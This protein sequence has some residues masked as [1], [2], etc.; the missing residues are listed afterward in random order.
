MEGQEYTIR[1]FQLNEI[2]I[3]DKSSD[4]YGIAIAKDIA[5]T[6]YGGLGGYYFDRNARFAKNENYA[7]GRLDV[8]AMFSDRFE[9]NGKQNYMNIGWQAV[10]IV[11]RIISGLVGRWMGRSEKAVVTAKDSLSIKEKNEEYALLEM[12]VKQ[13]D[14]IEQLQQ[15]SG[16]KLMPDNVPDDSDELLLWQAEFQRLPEEILFEIGIND[17]FDANGLNQA[18]KDKFL[19][20]GATD[21]IYGGEVE[22]GKDGVIRIIRHNPRNLIYSYS[23]FQDFRD[24]TWRGVATTIKIS[25]IRKKYGVEFGGKL[26]E[27][28]LWEIAQLSKNYQRNDNITWLDTWVN[29]YMR[30]Y[31]EWNLDSIKFEIKTVDNEKYTA[32]ETV[33]T[34]STIL[35]KGL[36]KTKSGNTRQK[37]LDNQEVLDDS[38]INI[39]R[40]VYLPQPKKLLEWGIKKNMIRPQDPKEIGNAEFSFSLYMYQNYKMRNIAIPE[41]I[42][43]PVNGMIFALLKIEQTVSVSKPPGSTI[44]WM[45][46]QN[47]SFGLGDKKDKEVDV[48]KL[49]NQTGDLYFNGW[50]AEG[51]PIPVPIQEIPNTG[52]L[53]QMQAWFS[54]YQFHYQTLKDQLGEDP[55]FITQAL[56]PRVT[57]GNVDTSQRAAEN[58]TDY[59]YDGFINFREDIGTKISCLLSDSVNFGAQAYRHLLSEKDIKG[60]EFSV[61]TKMLPTDAEIGLLDQRMNQLIATNP[62]A[63]MFIDTSKI[64]RMAKEDVKLAEKYYSLCMKK[65][66]TT[67]QAQTEQNQ[68]ANLQAQRQTA[69]DSGNAEM[70]QLQKKLDI[71]AKA[72]TERNQN[73]LKKIAL[74]GMFTVMASKDGEVQPEWKPIVN[75]MIQNIMLPLLKDNL[76]HTTTLGKTLQDNGMLQQQ[77][78]EQQQEQPQEPQQGQPQPDIQ[79]QQPQQVAA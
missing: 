51:K 72:D 74:Q 23:E 16:Q 68:Q 30:P 22:M 29:T 78:G 76:G 21:G 27:K 57:Q 5:S 26:T 77:D 38:N 8:K 69:I 62:Q 10:Q 59:I 54:D 19:W 40:G 28:E 25:E 71:Q 1:E 37:P 58:S 67:L 24:T 17:I 47:I 73:D 4:E 41:K 55:N 46:L 12:F 34:K 53:P 50:D 15:A 2:S 6:V 31:D 44:N 3:T 75:E 7:N 79:Q 36:P 43:Q 63:I 18:I 20:D 70:A 60:R 48:K 14:K 13:R 32:T 61:T 66:F 45:A 39:Y 49:Y 64:L 65:M 9:F 52:F 56:Q 42:E 33:K 11:N 35:E